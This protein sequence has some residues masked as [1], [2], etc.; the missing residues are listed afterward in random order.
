M[1]IRLC[2]EI[3]P[4]G[5]V[6][7]QIDHVTLVDCV[8]YSNLFCVLNQYELVFSRYQWYLVLL[9]GLVNRIDGQLSLKGVMESIGVY[10]VDG[11]RWLN[12]SFVFL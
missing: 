4:H 6:V 8:I 5:V 9:I 12:K 2:P 7:L 10:H 1:E 11:E 3:V